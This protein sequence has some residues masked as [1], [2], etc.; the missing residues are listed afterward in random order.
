MSDDYYHYYVPKVLLPE[1]L[2]RNEAMLTTEF[3]EMEI[4]SNNGTADVSFNF[5]GPGFGN[6]VLGVPC[7]T[8]FSVEIKQV[9]LC[10]EG[11]EVTL[12]GSGLPGSVNYTVKTES[13]AV[14]KGT[15]DI[16]CSIYGTPQSSMTLSA[17][18]YGRQIVMALEDMTTNIFDAKFGERGYPSISVGRPSAK[19]TII[20]KSGK[21]VTVSFVLA[22]SLGAEAEEELGVIPDGR[23]L[24]AG[25]YQLFLFSLG[26]S[27]YVVTFPDGRQ[28]K[29]MHV[30]S[31]EETY[32]Y[33]GLECQLITHPVIGTNSGYLTCRATY[34][35]KYTITPEVYTGAVKP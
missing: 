12:Y 33:S 13:G 26:G 29:H 9:P 15:I 28:S 24:N 5:R 2:G 10:I 25:A 7:I 14:K 34:E 31:K 22:P 8:R 6:R 1:M 27:Y 35:C 3:A 16:E 18:V 19:R 20:N 4:F 32:E 21:D 17:P 30:A 23:E 11:D